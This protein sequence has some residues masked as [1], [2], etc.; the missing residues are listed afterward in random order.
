MFPTALVLAIMSAGAGAGEH[1]TRLHE[2]RNRL[3]V[4]DP[5]P[6]LDFD[7]VLTRLGDAVVGRG[8]VSASAW[9]SMENA[10]QDV[11]RSGD[12]PLILR[13]AHGIRT[14][15]IGAAIFDDVAIGAGLR[16]TLDWYRAIHPD[17]ASL[18]WVQVIDRTR[19]WH[20]TLAET[21]MAPESASGPGGLV[22]VLHT[23]PDSWVLVRLFDVTAL[24]HEG[25]RMGHCVGSGAYDQAV[26]DP[27]RH[28]ILSI[29]D[30]NNRSKVTLELARGRP[31]STWMAVQAQG[32]ANSTPLKY[33]ER[34][35]EALGVIGMR[36]TDEISPQVRAL[37]PIP[38]LLEVASRDGRFAEVALRRLVLELRLEDFWGEVAPRGMMT[39]QVT[40]KDRAD[41]L[42]AVSVEAGIERI[43]LDSNIDARLCLRWRIQSWMRGTADL[44]IRDVWAPLDLETMRAMFDAARDV[45]QPGG[46]LVRFTD[47]GL[48]DEILSIQLRRPVPGL[49]DDP[50]ER[51]D[52]AQAAFIAAVIKA[53]GTEVTPSGPMARS[54]P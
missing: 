3:G 5:D 23:W 6:P 41:V 35:V 51:A 25:A 7:T 15:E 44:R 48:G 45:L 4:R 10:L 24:D 52:A 19:A 11:L 37:W 22:E 20:A 26:F 1:R 9:S 28:A 16:S 27:D 8:W 54:P 12:V 46:V 43:P 53:G 21:A 42:F 17:V 40:D 29:R 32:R 49:P 18:T 39:V 31:G 2:L 13:V 34:V 36:W 14:H 50:K 47:P 38:F 30:S 33:A